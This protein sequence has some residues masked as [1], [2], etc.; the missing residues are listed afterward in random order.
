MAKTKT[1]PV[2]PTAPKPVVK[3]TPAPVVQPTPKPVIKQH[4]VRE[5]SRDLVKWCE[6]I[7]FGAL[8][9]KN[10][11]VFTKIRELNEAINA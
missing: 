4:E 5:M 1:K 2:A 10:K 7:H 9:N 6:G 11:I 3:P 8:H